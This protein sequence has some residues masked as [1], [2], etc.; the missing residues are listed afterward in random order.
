VCP[1]IYTHSPKDD[2]ICSLCLMLLR[3]LCFYRQLIDAHK[4]THT[5]TQRDDFFGC[6]GKAVWRVFKM[7]VGRK[8]PCIATDMTKRNGAMMDFFYI[9]VLPVDDYDVK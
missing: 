3:N 5:H 6:V 8:I 4:D 7:T 9:S 2:I 1:I